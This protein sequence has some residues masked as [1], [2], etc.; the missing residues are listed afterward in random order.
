[1]AMVTT[2]SGATDLVVITYIEDPGLYR[3]NIFNEDAIAAGVFEDA[4]DVEGSTATEV[5]HNI[6]D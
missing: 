2:P 5:W 1:M 4:F 3:V 6:M